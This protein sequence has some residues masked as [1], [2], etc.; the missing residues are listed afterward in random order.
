MPPPVESHNG[1][2]RE[3]VVM[4]T[5]QET[6]EQLQRTTPDNRTSLSI[7]GLHPDYTYTYRVAAG[8]GIGTGPFSVSRSITMPEDG[9]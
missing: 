2:L 5:A 1:I 7:T 9:K 4:L 6:A 3:Y 8:T